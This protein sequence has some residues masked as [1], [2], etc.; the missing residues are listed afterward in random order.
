MIVGL[1]YYS[2]INR[3]YLP[4]EPVPLDEVLTEA[5]T[6]LSVAIETTKARIKV[7]AHLPE[8]LGRRDELVRLFQNL[9]ANAIKYGV[10]D[11]F[12]VVTVAARHDGC[13]WEISVTD[14]GV[15]IP[16]DETEYFRYL[17]A[18]ARGRCR[19]LWYRTG[20]LQ[21]DRRTPWWPHLGGIPAGRGIDI[22]LHSAGRSRRNLSLHVHR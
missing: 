21:E 16:A 5:V 4:E 20:E 2:H 22:F 11:R 1:L 19:G 18:P 17:P 14:N 12:P 8:I 10:P 6:N 3:R 15:G 13:F 9:T 7:P